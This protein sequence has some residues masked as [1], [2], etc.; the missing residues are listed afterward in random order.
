[1]LKNKYIM[2]DI[3]VTHVESTIDLKVHFICRAHRA[4]PYGTLNH[5]E[6]WDR[7][8]RFSALCVAAPFIVRGNV[9]VKLVSVLCHNI[10]EV[11]DVEDYVTEILKNDTSFKRALEKQGFDRMFSQTDIDRLAPPKEEADG[12][13]QED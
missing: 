6:V 8:S 7:N 9:S 12:D 4:V 2:Y 11:Q 5:R 13:E 10:D 1:M 3:E